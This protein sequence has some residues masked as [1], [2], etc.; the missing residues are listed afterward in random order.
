MAAGLGLGGNDEAFPLRDLLGVQQ[1]RPANRFG[2]LLP[3]RFTLGFLTPF[4]LSTKVF[5]I[6]RPMTRTRMGRSS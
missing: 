6:G 3:F 2:F 4:D 1:L 5:S